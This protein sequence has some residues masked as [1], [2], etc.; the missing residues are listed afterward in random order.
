MKTAL[1]VLSLVF[2]CAALAD[3]AG[4]RRCR[5]IT[6]ASARLACYD[7]LP[8]SGD[9]VAK[10]QP[11]P[12]APA[13]AAPAEAAALA[14]GPTEAQQAQMRF[15]LPAAQPKIVLE[16]L[17]STIPGHFEGWVPRTRI[18]LANGQIWQIAD[19]STRLLDLDNPKVTIR[20]A[21][22]GSFFMDFE[23]D[24]RSP[25]VVRVR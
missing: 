7:A 8:V 10:G 3:D 4:L 19:D 2:A 16:N 17:E 9:A 25:R 5:N 11:A 12:A 14:P 6:E 20:R 21:A 1:L 15:G 18:T 13:P 23:H 22:F 24:N